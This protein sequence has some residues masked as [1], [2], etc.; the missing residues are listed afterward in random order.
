MLWLTAYLIG[1]PP[2]GLHT[3]CMRRTLLFMRH[4]TKALR[5]NG[6]FNKHLPK[7]HPRDILIYRKEYFKVQKKKAR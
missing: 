5:C 4:A 1:F 6:L 7:Y 2:I 3:L